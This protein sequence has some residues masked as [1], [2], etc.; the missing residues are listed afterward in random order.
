MVEGLSPEGRDWGGGYSLMAVASVHTHG[1]YTM[2]ILKKRHTHTTARVWRSRFTMFVG[3]PGGWRRNCQSIHWVFEVLGIDKQSLLVVLCCWWDLRLFER[4][5]ILWFYQLQCAVHNQEKLHTGEQCLDHYDKV[6]IYT[7]LPCFALLIPL[8]CLHKVRY[9]HSLTEEEKREL[10]M[11]SG[12]RKR[13]A[14]GRGTPKILPRALQHTRCEN[15]GTTHGYPRYYYAKVVFQGKPTCGYL[16][17]EWVPPTVPSPWLAALGTNRMANAVVIITDINFLIRERGEARKLGDSCSSQAEKPVP[18]EKFQ[19][20]LPAT[21]LWHS[22]IQC[23]LM[24][25][26]MSKSCKSLKCFFFIP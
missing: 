8:F 12:Q 24:H 2:G 16:Y 23:K 13:E 1:G 15:V 9:C 14:L 6:W 3:G 22:M 5:Q 10:H 21:L 17:R 19:K 7:F 20:K 25:R 26:L 11:F 18:Q 4:S